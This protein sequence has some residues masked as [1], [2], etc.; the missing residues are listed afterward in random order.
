MSVTNN[1]VTAN[2][3]DITRQTL[4]LLG[5]NHSY[6]GYAYLIL[7]VHLVIE[8]PSILTYICKGLYI[9]IASQFDTTVFCVERNIRTIKNHLWKCGD[10]AVLHKIFG[11]LYC[12]KAPTNTAFI[13]ALS[14]YV[15][16]M[17]NNH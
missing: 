11:D 16:E 1:Y 15:M 4:R 12:C 9:D 13:D 7:A 6:K 17:L 14:C 2:V 8:N 3:F 10:K 5:I